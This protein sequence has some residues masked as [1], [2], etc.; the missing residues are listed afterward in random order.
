MPMNNTA[1]LLASSGRSFEVPG[2]RIQVLAADVERLWREGRERVRGKTLFLPS[3]KYIF[4]TEVHA[5]A[6]S[7]A[8]NAYLSFFPF[9]LMLLS[10]CR[11]WLHWD[12]AYRTVLQLLR[13]NL[14]SGADFMI[15]NLVAV[16]QGRTRLQVI[17]VLMLFFTSSGVF[18]PLEIALNKVWGFTRNRNFLMNQV[19]SFLLA[20][21]CGALAL[22]FVFAV[23][24]VRQAVQFLIGWVPSRTFIAGVSSI[25]LE[26][27]SVPLAA[28]LYFMIY[29]FLPNGRVPIA[30]VF[31]ASIAA[32]I[33]T[34]VGKGIYAWTLPMFRF[35]EVYGPLD[36]S[37]TLLFWAYVG[38]LILLFGA[39]LS[40]HMLVPEAPRETAPVAEGI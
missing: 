9:T 18:L 37:V 11:R 34:E 40:A 6:F 38:S 36:L 13:V 26:T 28:S 3:L 14:P 19:V 10:V 8:A 31:P 24:P 32:G 12:N 39:H 27:A 22:G 2:M 4:E 5:Y 29:Y 17:G 16:A 20:L 35:R 33:L 30:R 21:V 1:P 23:T 25:V 15:R 7:I